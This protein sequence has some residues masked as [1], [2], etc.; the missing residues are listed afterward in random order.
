ML[1]ILKFIFLVRFLFAYAFIFAIDIVD[2]IKVYLKT[3]AVDPFA[4]FQF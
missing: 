4:H 2:E 3:S 1:R